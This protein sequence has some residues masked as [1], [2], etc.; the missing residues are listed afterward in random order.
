MKNKGRWEIALKVE[1]ARQ[2]QL[3]KKKIIEITKYMNQYPQSVRQLSDK[4]KAGSLPLYTYKAVSDHN[5]ETVN[6]TE[7]LMGNTSV[8]EVPSSGSILKKGAFALLVPGNGKP[9]RICVGMLKVPT[10]RN[11]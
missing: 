8:V 5:K 3:I 10:L 11:D 1:D 7:T 4:S 9:C 2:A 6:L